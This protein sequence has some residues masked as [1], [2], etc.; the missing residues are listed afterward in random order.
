MS[1]QFGAVLAVGLAVFGLVFVFTQA[2]GD[3]GGG[4]GEDT[5]RMVLLE[6][7]YGE[8][9]EAK[10]ATRTVPL[11]SFTVGEARGDVM[12]FRTDRTSFS[13]GPLHE[14]SIKVDYE[15]TQPRGGSVEFEVL[16]RTGNGKVFVKVNG[17]TVFK[18]ALVAEGTPDIQIPEG[19]LKT[20]ENTIKIGTT[21]GGLISSSKY[22]IEDL[23][24]RVNDRKFHDRVDTFQMYP[25][26]LTDFVGGEVSFRVTDAVKTSPLAV[27]VNG[28]ELYDFSPVRG[29]QKF[30]ITPANANLSNGL[31]TIK[32]ETEGEASYTV[33][34]AAVTVRYIGS[35]QEVSVSE[36]LELDDAQLDFVERNNTV[37]E[38]SFDYVSLLGSP[39]QMNLT[40]NGNSHVFF[41][42][43]G[44]NTVEVSSELDEETTISLKSNGGFEMTRFKLVSRV[45]E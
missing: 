14:S 13:S 11:G 38:I 42:E 21:N 44:R 31:N 45:K 20:G 2:A 17:E 35:N 39:R 34:N 41:P 33:E 22:S 12:A 10:P 19:S 26:E 37:E 8:L 24:V 15:A 23:Q 40:V 1:N 3:L 7:S 4:S 9:G 28:R 30:N 43:N 32:F 27:S 36:T 29:I 16:G 18:N 25:Y 5:D 6:R